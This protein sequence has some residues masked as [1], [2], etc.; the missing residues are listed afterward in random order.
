MKVLITSVAS[1][2]LHP[3]KRF[4][5]D[6][7]LPF[8]NKRLV[9][10][11]ENIFCSKRPSGFSSFFFIRGASNLCQAMIRQVFRQQVSGC[12]TK[13]HLLGRFWG[14]KVVSCR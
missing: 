14:N 13:M 8:C 12:C 2:L 3:D 6:I 11:T 4:K 9:A 1:F 5:V 7:P 10:G